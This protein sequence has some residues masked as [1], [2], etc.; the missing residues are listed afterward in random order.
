[1]MS[2]KHKLK[3]NKHVNS[4]YRNYLYYK[5]KLLYLIDPY[6]AADQ[7]FYTVIKR[8]INL[9]NP[10]HLCEKIFWLQF[11][12]D[13]SLWT[14]CADKFRMRKYVE[15]KKCGEYL[16]IN[17]GHWDDPNEI[18][19]SSLPRQFVLKANNGC[20]SILIV[21]D[22]SSLNHADVKK[23][24]KKWMR[25][26]YGYLGAQTHYLK[27]KPCIIAEELLK[28]SDKLDYLSSQSLIDYKLWCFNGKP[29]AFFVCYNRTPVNV[30]IAL[31][32]T[33][34]IPLSEK[35]ISGPHYTFHPEVS[36]PKPECLEQMLEIAKLL[37]DPFPEVRVDFYNIN[38]KPVVGE[39]TFTTGIGYFTEDYYQYLGSKIDL[40]KEN[41]L[42]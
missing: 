39:M 13:T 4:L 37:S 30:S 28:Q 24:L 7:A 22:K 2:L 21:N 1:M 42:K 11:N 26:P 34:W 25:R 40:S 29:E 36:I 20:E 6:L 18:D 5:Y 3:I 14:I 10:K 8:H 31:Y 23:Q 9:E 38:G 35:I 41:I 33:Q 12:T 16:P 15:Q 27:I 17:L 32:D 19:F